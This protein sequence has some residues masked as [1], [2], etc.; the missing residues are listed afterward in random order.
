MNY[1]LQHKHSP[2]K[3]H[4]TLKTIIGRTGSRNIPPLANTEGTITTDDI[5]KATLLN[6]HFAKQSHIELN[7]RQRPLNDNRGQPPNMDSINISSRE[8]LYTLNTLDPNKSCGRSSDD[9][10]P[11]ILK[12][13]ALLVYEP[14]TRLY[15]KCLQEGSYPSIWKDANVHPIYKRKGSPSDP[16]NYRPI[17]LL[18]CLSKVYGKIIFKHIYKHLTD[19]Q[20]I[21]DRQSGYRPGHSTQLQLLHLT[22]NMYSNI[23]K[24]NGFTTI[25]LDISKYFDKIWHKGL[26]HKC[27]YEFGITG[28]L[29][30]WLASYL[31]DRNQRVR[32]GETFSPTVTINA[33]CPQGSVLGPLLALMYLNGITNV[34]EN[35][36]LLFADDITLYTSHKSHNVIQA[37]Q[38][39]QKDLNL[40]YSYGREWLIT[41]NAAK[42]IMQTFSTKRDIQVPQLTFGDNPIQQANEHKHLG[43]TLSKDLRFHSHV[44]EIIQKVNRAISPIYPI[45]KYIPREVLAQ[46]YL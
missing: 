17:S 29:L 22:H 11:T 34:I 12:L 13:V 19:N 37:Q 9:L 32:V 18:P 10:P 27:K 1:L 6:S 46:I 36:A 39:L 20:L 33:G 5:Q 15:N 44:N 16:T 43:L 25:Y 35:D 8:V 21:S 30:Q 41:F 24:G 42:T 45:A 40:I 2:F 31:K 28:T 3:Y 14:L 23:D 26:L 7:D 4:N 38:S